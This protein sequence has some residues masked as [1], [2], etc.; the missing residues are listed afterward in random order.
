MNICSD[1]FSDSELDAFI[2][3]QN[4][5]G[6]CDICSSTDNSTILI[7]E[8]EDFFQELIDNYQVWDTG[9]PIKNKI[10]DHWSL[11]SSHKIASKILNYILPKLKTEITNSEVGVDYID[12]IIENY[13]YW[14]K[15]KDELKWE[16]RF[17]TN[18]EL[19]T[20]DL[21]W[22]GFFNAQYI[23]T[24]DV[25][26]YR[27]RVHYKSGD[28]AYTPEKMSCPDPEIVNSGRLNPSG[29]PVLYLSD[30]EETILY[31]VRASF[32]D[33]VSVG[34]FK[35][36]MSNHSI[37]IVDFTEDVSIFNP[38]YVNNTIKSKLLKGNISRDLSK[39]MRRYDSELEYI[40]TQFICEFIRVVTGANGI[41]FQSSLHPKGKNVVIFD[42]DLMECTE[43]SL[44]KVNNVTLSSKDR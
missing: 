10:Q 34:K 12:E 31:E 43:V 29:I 5:L 2:K 38:G 27:A 18:V 42:E 19:L 37:N 32:L 7:D 40:P 1:C 4:N 24:P 20:E 44:V 15:L 26:L 23:L 41:R 6:K 33:E 22:D 30:N 35:L 3:S 28:P 25:T 17:V 16:K 21:G 36:R 8:L 39:P 13:S 11:F 9:E 14:E